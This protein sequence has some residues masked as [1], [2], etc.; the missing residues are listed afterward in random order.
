[1]TFPGSLDNGILISGAAY[2]LVREAHR[3]RHSH[4]GDRGKRGDQS[5]AMLRNSFRSSVNVY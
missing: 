4:A 1:M 3:K 5:G 2:S